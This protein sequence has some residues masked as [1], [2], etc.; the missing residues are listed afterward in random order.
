M[1]FVG[2]KFLMD[3]NNGPLPNTGNAERV[4]GWA[5]DADLSLESCSDG[6]LY[7]WTVHG[8]MA[9]RKVNTGTGAEK[10]GCRARIELMGMMVLKTGSVWGCPGTVCGKGREGFGIF[11]YPMRW[12]GHLL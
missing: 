4:A 1:K 3:K 11:L 9:T 12:L 10:R 6:V 5:R 2:Q 8:R 7:L